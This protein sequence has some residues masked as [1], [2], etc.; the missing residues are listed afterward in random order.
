VLARQELDEAGDREPR[1]PIAHMRTGK[2]GTTETPMISSTSPLGDAPDCI[3]D[4]SHKVRQ[5]HVHRPERGQRHHTLLSP[6]EHTIISYLLLY[7]VLT[8]SQLVQMTSR[9]VRTVTYGLN[10]L[11]RTASWEWLTTVVHATLTGSIRQR[12]RAN[13]PN[14]MFLAHAVAV[15][16]VWL[17][18][19]SQAPSRFRV[20]RWQLLT[21]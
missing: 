6:T 7:R 16:D 17:A 4:P 15:A 8:T 14:P 13:A 5:L 10:R 20:T 9:P 18:L 19:T 2:E 3:R 21:R 11:H 1:L 12:S